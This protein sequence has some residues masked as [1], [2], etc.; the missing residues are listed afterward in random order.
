MRIEY[1]NRAVSTIKR[2]LTEGKN[3][4]DGQLQLPVVRHDLKIEFNYHSLRHT[5]ATMLIQAGA[6]IKNVI[7]QRKGLNRKILFNRFSPFSAVQG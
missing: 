5:H 4:K 7:I 2:Q 6:P 1:H 3:K